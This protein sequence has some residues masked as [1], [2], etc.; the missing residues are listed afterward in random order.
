MIAIIAGRDK[1]IP[2]ELSMNLV[3]HW[4]GDSHFVVIK[5]ADHNSISNYPEYW[6]NIMSFLT[7]I[8]ERSV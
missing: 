8:G 6:Y 4:G 7:E 2:N 3:E 1:I 5:N